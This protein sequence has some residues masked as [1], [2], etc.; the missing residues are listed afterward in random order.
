MKETV[1][2]ILKSDLNNSRGSMLQEKVA[3]I[4]TS[5]PNDKHSWSGTNHYIWKN[6][7]SQFSQIDVLG[8]AEPKFTV[9]ICKVI[10]AFSLMLGKRFDYR[11]STMYAK[12]CANLFAK[13]LEGKNYDLIISPAGVAY[14]AYLKTKTP[15]VLVLDRTIAGTINYHTIFTKLW[16]FSE[17]QSINTDK[18]AMHNCELTIFS[19]QWAA[20]IAIKEYKLPKEKTLVVP[21]GANMDVLP[22]A[23]FVFRNKSS[24]SEKKCNLL[25]I[26]VYWENKGVDI[27]VN[28][29]KELVMLGVDAKLTV[30]GC[31]APVGF[32]NERVTIIPFLNKNTAEGLKKLEELF[33]SHTFFIL[34]TRFDC[35][36]IV[37]CEASAYA[38]PILSSNTG[39]VAGHI[40]EG[41]NGF[42]IGYNDSGKG[43][44]SKIAEVLNEKGCYEMLIK[45]T[46]DEYDQHLNWKSWT[47]SFVKAISKLP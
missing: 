15:K 17:Q 19:S 10:H 24:L 1:K 11:H 36:P 5:D 30:C 21:F 47:E 9:F 35:T 32:K 14:V 45:T 44:A 25:L 40:T 12:A 16:K 27:A 31:E 43:Y 3:Y 2:P 46:R 20:D 18:V 28:A 13:K 42:L 38:L 7:Q 39:G 22:S 41:K 23:D 34:P 29:V 4:T 26:G 37:Y 8:P 33:L 6:L